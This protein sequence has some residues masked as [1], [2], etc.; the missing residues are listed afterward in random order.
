MLA[1]DRAGLYLKLQY[2]FSS[3]VRSIY[4]KTLCD[5]V[6]RNICNGCKISVIEACEL[7]KMP[8]GMKYLIDLCDV[9]KAN[10]V[11]R[12]CRFCFTHIILLWKEDVAAFD[13]T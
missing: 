8:V 10:N 1:E 5:A 4:W 6:L 2:V 13:T 3:Y 11:F 12:V 7:D 9:C